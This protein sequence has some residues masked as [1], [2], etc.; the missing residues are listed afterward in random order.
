MADLEGAQLGTCHVLRRIGRG[1]MGEVYLAEQT[2]LG[3]QVAVKVLPSER[4]EPDR[5]GQATQR[6]T[7]EAQA[8][9]ALDHPHILPLYEYGE[10]EG[11]HYLVMPYVPTGSLADLLAP[12]PTAGASQRPHLTL[13]LAPALAIDLISQAAEALQYAHDRHLMHLD[14]KPQNLLVRLLSSREGLSLPLASAT[15]TMLAALSGVSASQSPSPLRL[16]VFLADF[17]LARLMTWTSGQSGVM[18]TPLYTAPEQY[19]GRP[20]PAT[21]QYALACVA[22]LLLTGQPVFSGSLVELYHQHL[23]VTPRLASSVNPQLPAGVDRVLAR[24]LAKAPQQRY[25][26][27]QEFAQ[28]LAQACLASVG[29]SAGTAYAAANAGAMLLPTERGKVPGA[30]PSAADPSRTVLEPPDAGQWD[31]PP[32][33][34]STWPDSRSSAPP[35]TVTPSGPWH[36]SSGS[37]TPDAPPARLPARP[38]AP[39]PFY[40]RK[41][42]VFAGLAALILVSALTAAAVKVWA[43]SS[44]LT[45]LVVSPGNASLATG[46][47][48]QL[49][50]TGHYAD[51]SLHRLTDGIAWRSSD[52]A[53]VTITSGGLAK[54]VGPGTATISA[55][56][57]GVSGSATLTVS[58]HPKPT[59]TPTSAPQP[60]ATSG[61]RSGPSSAPVAFRVSGVTVAA[62]YTAYNGTCRSKGSFT[63]TATITAPAGTNGGSVTYE[64][65]LSDGT[66]GS[67]Q[68]VSF[69]PGATS[70]AVSTTWS[71]SGSVGGETF[72]EAVQVTAPNVVSS[73]RATI[74]WLCPLTVAGSQAT[75]SPTTYPCSSQFY[76][77]TLTGSLYFGATTGGTVSYHWYESGPYTS[78]SMGDAT[79]TVAPN[80]AGADVSY[81]WNIAQTSTDGTYTV[82]LVVTA[83]NGV[84]LGQPITSNDASFSHSCA[85]PT[86]Y[87][88]P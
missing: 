52:R 83:I 36:G 22:Y 26:T 31:S 19:Q 44:H 68:T 2:T 4:A 67:P 88:T 7:R 71:P 17:G 10:Q 57:N 58:A 41:G 14:V 75:V 60:T 5:A 55:T 30:S 24:A 77:M 46:E 61:S 11:L 35:P 23:S 79:I 43:G 53:V 51:R 9:A 3:R 70:R 37:R 50:A 66:T 64:W 25:T 81:G 29:A 76:T 74:T 78:G 73:N 18:G 40:S 48:L 28:A 20:E 34:E 16:H 85:T 8:V 1:G 72:W 47:S 80:V 32:P 62:N 45:A 65:L 82:Q 84:A 33:F 49:S 87:P 59:P 27:V 6:F 86:P 13:P 56:S 15:Q 12:V 69:A 42:L 39:S 54:A 63:F 21:D 38:R